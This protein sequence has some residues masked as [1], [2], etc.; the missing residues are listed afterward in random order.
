MLQYID[1]INQIAG[2][3]KTEIYGPL[4]H[5]KYL[6]DL[7]KIYIHSLKLKTIVNNFLSGENISNQLDVTDEIIDPVKFLQ[8][9]VA[10]LNEKFQSK[11]TIDE[12]NQELL[13]DIKINQKILAD[14]V[15]KIVGSI[16]KINSDLSIK[17][18]VATDHMD[19]IVIIFYPNQIMAMEVIKSHIDSAI[20][21]ATLDSQGL[22]LEIS[23]SN[24]NVSLVLTIPS[25][26]VIKRK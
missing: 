10:S 3:L 14:I 21:E 4:P 17:V 23:P 19:R 26:R 1:M 9:F 13:S 12:V 6:E 20:T 11:V 18:A 2:V 7:N 5:K 22:L 24:N 8:G 25:Y 15:R 16:F